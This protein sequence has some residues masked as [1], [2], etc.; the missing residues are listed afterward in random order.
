VF[1]RQAAPASTVVWTKG[2]PMAGHTRPWEDAGYCPST[3]G[4][5]VASLMFPGGCRQ[6]HGPA[7]VNST[8]AGE[9][10]ACLVVSLLK[11]DGLRGLATLPGEQTV[12]QER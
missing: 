12:A 3:P 8:A 1:A 5:A 9:P 10:E 11:H 7:M 4:E 2:L 6:A